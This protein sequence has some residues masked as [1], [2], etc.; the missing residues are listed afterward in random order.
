MKTVILIIFMFLHH[1]FLL[2]GSGSTYIYGHC[3]ATYKRN[4]TKEECYRFVAN[5]KINF[6]VSLFSILD[7]NSFEVFCV[8]ELL[9]Q[10]NFNL[11]KNWTSVSLSKKLF[12]FLTY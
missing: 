5:G 2:E 10:Q 9:A 7:P 8:N 12:V 3:D 4:M 11:Q 6:C 1:I